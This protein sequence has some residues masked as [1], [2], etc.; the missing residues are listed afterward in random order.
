MLG[1]RSSAS[2]GAAVVILVASTLTASTA[3]ASKEK[4]R[5]EYCG[6]NG[7][8][9]EKLHNGTRWTMCWRVDAKTGLVLEKIAVQAP[10]ETVP[11]TVIDSAALA[12][13]N[14][15]YD[16]GANEWN[17]ITS[18]GFGDRYMQ[19]MT[20]EE[21]PG[22][23][24]YGQWLGTGQDTKSVL[25]VSEEETGFAYRAKTGN[26]TGTGP[27]Y[28]KQGHDLVLRTISKIDWYEYVTEWRFADDGTISTALGATG[29]L[30]PSDYT[31]ADYGWPI[32]TNLAD[33]STNHYHSAFWKINWN[34]G[35][36]GNEAVEQYDTAPTGE[37]GRRAAILRTTKTDIPVE[38]SFNT[39]NRRWW[40]VV[41]PTLNKDGH[42]RSYELELGASDAYEVHPETAPDVSFTQYR[43][44][45]KFASFNQDPECTA[46]SLPEYVNGES[47]TDPVMWVRVGF[48]HIPRD[49]DQSPMPFHWQGFTLVPRDF[50][51]QNMLTPDTRRYVNGRVGRPTS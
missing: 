5:A 31:T 12:Q 25:C 10:G 28:T 34:I 4:D 32:G 18:Y 50:T 21:C 35:G 29:D 13:L 16:S 15:P 36:A 44:C 19:P 26:T 33:F 51:A 41:S 30:A 22:G 39:A 45:E 47:M 3:Q 6:S 43:A 14:V 24:V 8:V 49:E 20:K 7:L 46:T 37:V 40:R 48:H 38:G 11:T 2:V 9:N 27:L 1:R 42:K 17:D 23:K